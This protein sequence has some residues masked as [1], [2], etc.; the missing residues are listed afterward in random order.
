MNQDPRLINDDIIESLLR[1]YPQLIL[2]LATGNALRA[3]EG[4]VNAHPVQVID[5]GHWCSVTMA[6]GEVRHAQQTP[7]GEKGIAAAVLSLSDTSRATALFNH[8]LPGPKWRISAI[9]PQGRTLC[10][11][12]DGRRDGYVVTDDI[13][14]H[15]STF[16]V[17]CSQAATHGKDLFANAWSAAKPGWR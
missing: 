13:V 4:E 5:Y 10:A 7:L 3:W 2:T 14:A 6:F 16:E 12:P 8:D 11:G 17:P 15:L 1:R 9:A